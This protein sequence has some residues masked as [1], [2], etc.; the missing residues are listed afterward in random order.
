MRIV[1]LT[2]NAVRHKYLANTLTKAAD[3]A[4]VISECKGNDILD[5]ESLGR[6]LTPL[7][8]HFYSRHLAEKKFF[9]GN[10]AFTARTLPMLEKEVNLKYPYEVV[11][12]FNPDM[13]FVFGSSIIREPM[14]SAV[15]SGRFINLHLGMSPYYRGAGTNFWPFV[16]KELEYVG[17]TIIHID[18]GVDTGDIIT[19]V[20]PK[21]ELHD[22][23]HTVGCKVIQSSAE[24][25]VRLMGMVREGKTLPRVKQW[26]TPNKHYYRKKD[27]N[28]EILNKYLENLKNGLV[29]E[30]LAAPP[31]HIEM[32]TLQP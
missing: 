20:R 16:N 23:V 28:E 17:S 7:E 32:V 3:E 14:L 29:E 9:A 10:D 8:N 30:Y 18:A 15:P 6:P 31:K 11:K 27:F 13:M 5:A 2:S 25:L 4:L 22:T 21:I 26:Q 19:H 1:I 12:S 24:M